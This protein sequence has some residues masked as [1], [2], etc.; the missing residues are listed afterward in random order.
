MAPSI[1]DQVPHFARFESHWHPWELREVQSRDYFLHRLACQILAL[2]EEDVGSSRL[3]L[4]LKQRGAPRIIIL[5][6]LTCPVVPDG[7]YVV[8]PSHGA[9]VVLQSLYSGSEGFLPQSRRGRT[10]S[11]CLA[12]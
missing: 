2:V 6:P 7:P 11:T 1:L 12:L 10:S 8:T 9:E 5:K 4:V 3:H